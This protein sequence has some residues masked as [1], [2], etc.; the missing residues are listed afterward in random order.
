MARLPV[1]SKAPPDPTE[2]KGLTEMM[3]SFWAKC[4]GSLVIAGRKKEGYQWEGQ[5]HVSI[6]QFALGHYR[7][8]RPRHCSGQAGRRDYEAVTR[9]GT[10]FTVSRANVSR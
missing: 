5:N 1:F 10:L 8:K 7:T 4:D 3:A 2:T 6:D 9:T